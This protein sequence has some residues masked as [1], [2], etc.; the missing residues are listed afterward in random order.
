MDFGMAPII[1]RADY[2]YCSLLAIVVNEAGW[3]IKAFIAGNKDEDRKVGASRVDAKLGETEVH[4][5][6]VKWGYLL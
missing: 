1:V 2:P 3:F 4:L 5:G 6:E